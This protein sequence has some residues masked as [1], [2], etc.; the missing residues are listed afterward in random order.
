[1]LMVEGTD[2]ESSVKATSRIAG[3]EY[4]E[5]YEYVLRIDYNYEESRPA[6]SDPRPRG[7]AYDD[8][9]FD[10]SVRD[11]GFGFGQKSIR[12]SS[13][14]SPYWSAACRVIQGRRKGSNDLASCVGRWCG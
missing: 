12:Q 2:V 6:P 4:V 1:M 13:D 10:W 7:A 9:R 5:V 3:T 8:I 11:N 14:R